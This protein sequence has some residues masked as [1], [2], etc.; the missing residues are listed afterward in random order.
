MKINSNK[1]LLMEN[2]YHA[3]R[4]TYEC[5]IVCVKNGMDA[6]AKSIDSGQPAQDAQADLGQNFLMLIISYISKY[7]TIL[8]FICLFR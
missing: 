6:S 1:Q 4:S 3:C 8:I 2:K 7:H 5:P